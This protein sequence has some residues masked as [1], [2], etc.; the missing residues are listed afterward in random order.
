MVLQLILLQ[1][2]SSATLEKGLKIVIGPCGLEGAHHS[3]RDGGQQDG[4]TFFGR[5]KSIK[6][7]ANMTQSVENTTMVIIDFVRFLIERSRE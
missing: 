3:F 6:K 5:K 4:I 1:V 2:I 7:V